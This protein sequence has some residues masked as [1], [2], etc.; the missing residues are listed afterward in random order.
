MTRM[1]LYLIL[2]MVFLVI[3]NSTSADTS[4]EDTGT[5]TT[6]HLGQGITFPHLGLN[7]GGYISLL[8]ED[9]KDRDW[10][11][12]AKD[13]SLFFSKKF[14][15]RW[16]LFS[17]VEIGQALDISTNGVSDRDSEFDLERIYTDYRATKEVTLRFGKFLTP[18]GHWN[19]IHADPLVWTVDRPLTTAAPF[20]R[21][22][23]GIMLYG[24]FSA[25]QNDWDYNLFIDDSDLLDPAQQKELAFENGDTKIS[26]HNAFKRAAGAHISYHFL[27]DSA[28]IG[29][30]YLHYEMYDLREW[31]ELYGLDALWTYKRFEVSGEWISRLSSGNVENNEHGGFIQIVLSLTDHLYVIGRQE[32][33]KS[34]LLIPI[35]TITS[36][37]L[38]YR[39]HPAIAIKFE[40]RGGHNNEVLM[41]SG[42]LASLAVLF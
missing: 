29:A 20:A 23:T 4:T 10:R 35:A 6:Y 12:N 31:K 15:N 19:Q 36:T 34:A 28:N 30:S 27:D 40:Y 26:P 24:S 2:G 39:P 14:S 33:Y 25:L 5:H 9:V 7:I 42:W 11:I 8:Y 3:S 37:G 18:V 32:R 1:R 17:E 16:Q 41:P 38:T 22:A 13:L 21:H